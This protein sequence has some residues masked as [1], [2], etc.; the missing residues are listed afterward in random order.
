[1]NNDRY[2]TGE[3]AERNKNWHSGDSTWKAMQILKIIK[4]NNIHPMNIVEIGCGAGR[5][6]DE[7][8]KESYFS[9]GH[10][11]GY[12]ISPQA[13]SLCRTIESSKCNFFCLDFFAE[14]RACRSVDMLL[15]IDVMENV[16]DY[17]GFI[18][19]CK[20]EAEYKIYHIPLD[21][22]VY[23]LMKNMYLDRRYAVG[24][25]H[26]FTADS[27]I[28]TLKDTEHKIIDYF[29]TNIC[30]LEFKQNPSIKKAIAN[31][32]LKSF[33]KINLPLTAKI[34]GG[35]SLLVLTR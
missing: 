31:I 7:L 11:T 33:A 28:A 3:Y 8:S 2:I 9:G 17:I 4:K 13:I 19:K 12:D 30:F 1:M 23:T 15:V 21:I 16:S 5:I 10:F 34:F 32:L 20:D 25:L 35:Y 29:Y 22:S 26:Y 14:E 18:E 24:H 6:L 27:A